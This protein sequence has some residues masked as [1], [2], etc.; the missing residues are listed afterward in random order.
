M[1]L[2]VQLGYANPDAMLR[3]MTTGQLNEWIAY[4]RLEP[5][6]TGALDWLLAH[7]KALFV[8]SHL[9]KGR[10]PYKPEKLLTFREEKEDLDY[11]YDEKDGDW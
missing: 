9:K 10:R 11:L 7:F 8:N 2:A 4:Y 5:F 3:E 6:G 1:R